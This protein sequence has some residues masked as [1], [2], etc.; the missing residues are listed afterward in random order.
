MRSFSETSLRLIRGRTV[1]PQGVEEHAGHTLLCRPERL[2]R[3]EERPRRVERCTPGHAPDHRCAREGSDPIEQLLLEDRTGEGGQ[4]RIAPQARP[5]VA[6]PPQD[7]AENDAQ[8]LRGMPGV[9]DRR[10]D[11]S[12]A[13]ICC[14]RFAIS[15]QDVLQHQRLGLLVQDDLTAGRQ[16]WKTLSRPGHASSATCRVEPG[17]GDECSNRNSLRWFPMKSRTVGTALSG[18]R[19]RPR[20]SCCKNTVALSVGRKT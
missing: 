12:S 14:Q 2:R 10:L 20:P 11:C 5:R 9:P 13:T 7:V 6:A 16:E 1:V 8:A 3:M 17:W 4:V 18:V 19:H 15:E